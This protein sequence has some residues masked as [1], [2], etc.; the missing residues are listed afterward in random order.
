MMANM[1]V[2]NIWI[3]IDNLRKR[4]QE[5]VKIWKGG[6]SSKQTFGTCHK[7]SEK[8]STKDCHRQPEEQGAI[9]IVIDNMKNSEL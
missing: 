6:R 9:K 7:Y 5:S 1:G 2:E 4:K 8:L 3:V